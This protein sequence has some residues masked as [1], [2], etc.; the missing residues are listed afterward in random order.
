MMPAMRRI[1]VGDVQ[2]CLGPLRALLDAVGFR[3]GTDRLHPV[4]DLVNKGPDSEGVVRLCR[5]L[6]AEGVIGNQDRW[7]LEQGRLRDPALRQWLE[8]QPV[9]RVFADLILVHGGLH[10]KWEEAR[11]AALTPDETDY[12]LTV[13]YCDPDG[14]R[15]PSDWPPPGPPF[16][17]WDDFYTGSRRVVFGH[18][19]RRGL[20]VRP[21]CVGLDT[22][23]VYG[24]KLSAWIAEED[25]V[26]QV[27][28]LRAQG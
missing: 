21:Q 14:N 26:V 20:V 1:F 18:W 28:G 10:P 16:R 2:G 3:P 23:C 8:G 17:P 13:R 4:G 22:G 7:Y 19:A 6:G 9:V 5:E 12:A 11:L 15:P 25:R 24:G 27:E